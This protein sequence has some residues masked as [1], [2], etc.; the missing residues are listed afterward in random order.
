M[1]LCGV[2]E[3]PLSDISAPYELF[4]LLVSL[5]VS[6][7]AHATLSDGTDGGANGTSRDIDPGSPLV[8]LMFREAVSGS[9]WGSASRG[10]HF[11]TANPGLIPIFSPNFHK[12]PSRSNMN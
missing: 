6:T 1:M 12:R 7:C 10:V 9:L 5:S 4:M 11:I 3:K 8:V 2:S